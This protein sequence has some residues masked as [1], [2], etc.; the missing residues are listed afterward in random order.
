MSTAAI[1]PRSVL[2]T[3]WGFVIWT[4]AFA[5]LY[6]VLSIG[7]RFGWESVSVAPGVTL[8]RAVLVLL[9]A[10]SLFANLLFAIGARR[11]ALTMQSNSSTT[12]RFLHSVALWSAIAAL[13]ST[14]LTF[15]PVFALSACV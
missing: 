4:V 11:L 7:C 2:L 13:A 1:R 5:A 12:K 6:S 10:L 9:F 3:V 15:L 8:Q 14:T